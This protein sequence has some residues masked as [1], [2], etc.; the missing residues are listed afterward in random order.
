MREV[1]GEKGK[2]TPCALRPAASLSQSRGRCYLDSRP[3]GGVS[4]QGCE[5][6]LRPRTRLHVFQGR[7]INCALAIGRRPLIPGTAQRA[8]CGALE[9]YISAILSDM[10]ELMLQGSG[11]RGQAAEGGGGT[12]RVLSPFPASSSAFRP[13][14]ARA[15]PPSLLAILACKHRVSTPCRPP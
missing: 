15:E 3:P 5:S 10:P 8:W 12:S 1:Q 2:R 7:G 14:P 13:R 4:G 6:V 11:D 9:A